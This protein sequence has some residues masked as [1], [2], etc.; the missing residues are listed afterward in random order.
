MILKMFIMKLR[1]TRNKKKARHF[2]NNQSN[3]RQKVILTCGSVC[4]LLFFFFILQHNK[5]I[6]FLIKTDRFKT[7][8]VVVVVVK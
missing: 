4:V 6:K 7:F 3:F 1:R 2:E 5:L 8:F